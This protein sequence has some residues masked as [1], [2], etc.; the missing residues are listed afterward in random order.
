MQDMIGYGVNRIGSYGNL[1]NQ[2]QVVALIDE[3]CHVRTD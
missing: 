2:Q 1:D 3:V